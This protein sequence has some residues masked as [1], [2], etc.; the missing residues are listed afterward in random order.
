VKTSAIS[1]IFRTA[2]LIFG[3]IR[4]WRPCIRSSNNGIINFLRP[5]FEKRVKDISSQAGIEVRKG[6][7]LGHFAYGGSLVILLFEK[8]RFTQ[9][10]VQQGQQI[11]VFNPPHP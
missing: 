11:G 10:S 8:G 6:E 1:R 9:V 3:G 5:V 2:R 4:I 7:R